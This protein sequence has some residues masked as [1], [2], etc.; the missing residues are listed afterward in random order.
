MTTQ[1]IT[2]FKAMSAKMDYLNQRHKVLSQNIANSDTPN[3]KG[4]DLAPTDFG[5]VMKNITKDNSVSM[6][7][8]QAGHMPT[9][10][11]VDIGKVRIA[12]DPYEVAPD[13]NAVNLE[14]Q[15][16]KSNQTQMDYNLML[17]L[18]RNNIDLMRIANGKGP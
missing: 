2:L 18:Y 13:K 11:Q 9:P 5:R 16:M 7:S 8:T 15:L 17:S 3:Y 1:N 6:T 4:G 10:N 14:E 12:K